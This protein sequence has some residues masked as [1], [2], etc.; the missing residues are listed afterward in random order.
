MTHK[1]SHIE[2]LELTDERLEKLERRLA[3]RNS[4]QV[5]LGYVKREKE[6]RMQRTATGRA[7]W[8]MGL[9]LGAI[10][11]AFL[12][13]FIAYLGFIYVESEADKRQEVLIWLMNVALAAIWMICV[14]SGGLF[15]LAKPESRWTRLSIQVKWGLKSLAVLWVA[16]PFLILAMIIGLTILDQI[17]VE[18]SSEMLSRLIMWVMLGGN[19]GVPLAATV[20]FA[21]FLVLKSVI[22]KINSRLSDS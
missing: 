16:G 19:L 18:V 13:L 2:L 8:G 7:T 21:V 4:G 6:Y 22:P 11:V 9:G 10:V 20:V 5:T 15:L 12:T 14:I 1:K 17:G 3:K